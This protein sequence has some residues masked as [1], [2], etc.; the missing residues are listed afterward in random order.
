MPRNMEFKVFLY[1]L[2]HFQ[3]NISKIN[4]LKAAT[5][6]GTWAVPREMGH[7]LGAGTAAQLV[8]RKVQRKRGY[9]CRFVGENYFGFRI[10]PLLKILMK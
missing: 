7:T 9:S 1:S 5:G 3:V 6:E 2:I 4:T 10:L 8:M